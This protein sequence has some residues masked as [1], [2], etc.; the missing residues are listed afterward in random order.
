MISHPDQRANIPTLQL[1]FR[2]TSDLHPVM[3]DR[4]MRLWSD[5]V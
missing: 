4:P 3:L 2:T 5:F 1:I